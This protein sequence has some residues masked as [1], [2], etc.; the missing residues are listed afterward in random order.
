MDIIVKNARQH[1]L[2]GID[3][4]IPRNQLVIFTGVSGSGKSSLVFDTLTAEAQ[5]QFFES[6]ST[7]SRKYLPKYSHPEVDEISNLS[8]VIVIDQKRLGRNLRSTVG[9]VTQIYTYMRLLFSRCGRPTIGNSS[10]FSFNTVE[11]ACSECKGLG[12]KL[13]LDKDRLLNW[14]NSINE[15]AIQSSEYT[16]GGRR[17][18][19]VK[20]SR[21]FKM[22]K[23][24]KEFSKEEIEKLLFSDR[25]ELTDTNEQGFVQSYGFEGLVVGI[26]RRRFDK[27]GSSDLSNKQSGRYFSLVFCDICQG[28]RLNKEAN[29]VRLNGKNISDLTNMQLTDLKAFLS[30]IKGPVAEPIINKMSEA[31]ASLIEIGVGYLSLNRSVATLSGGESQRVK[32]SKQL[33]CSL[34][35][36]IYVLDE[37][38]VGLHSR[39]INQLIKQ[40]VKLKEQ[41]NSV[42]VVEHDAEIIKAADQIVDIG[43]KAGRLGGNLVFQGSLAGLKKSVKSETASGLVGRKGL[44]KKVYRKPSGCLEIKKASL[45]NLKEIDVKIPTEVLCGV[46]GVAGSGKSSL[47]LDILAKKYSSAVV[48]DQSAVGR[49]TKSIPATYIGVFD[50][51]RKKF[52]QVTGQKIGEFSFNSSGGCMKCKGFGYKKVEMHFL[53]DVLVLC[54]L[55]KGKRYK[56]EMTNYKVR[57]KNIMDVLEMT[58]LEAYDF[59]EDKKIKKRLEILKAV[60]LDYLELGQPLNTLSGG[61][62]QRIKLASQLHKNGNIYI[63]DEPTTGLHMTDIDKLM[64]LLNRLVEAGNTV[65]VIEHNLDV[66][67]QADWIIDLGPEGGEKGGEI[68]FEGTPLELLDEKRS[69]TGHWLR[70]TKL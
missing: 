1:N 39:D 38:S 3:I 46:T 34:V 67:G 6:L 37:P 35:E 31:L 14:D 10:L 21:L 51:I 8:P 43:P 25:I 20:A 29:K 61:E 32:M 54:S 45:H 70:K 11:G 22:D 4:K 17:W 68:V 23:P 28:S 27:R 49:S 62:A 48:V 47:I 66:I 19:I 36:L 7:Q 59:F 13:L 44:L 64:E 5:R 50:L 41:G 33:G 16:V 53:D 2:K 65:I 57:D 26:K 55:C 69:H 18:N 56:T 40:L 42:L 15:G 52:S 63:L 24:L 60:G 30:E 9:T 12:E 58:A